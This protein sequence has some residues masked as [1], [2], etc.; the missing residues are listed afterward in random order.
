[1]FQ[2]DT[3]DQFLSVGKRSEK[4][5]RR[6]LTSLAVFVGPV[7]AG[8]QLTDGHV[9]FQ[10]VDTAIGVRML[11]PYDSQ[12]FAQSAHF[13]RT[14]DC[15]SARVHEIDHVVHDVGVVVRQ[16]NDI[17]TGV[18][19]RTSIEGRVQIGTCRRQYRTVGERHALARNQRR[20]AEEAAMTKVNEKRGEFPGVF[21][22]DVIDAERRAA[23]SDTEHC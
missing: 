3:V 10:L 15:R 19:D 23:C 13:D 6:C 7:V 22:F 4:F 14:S 18:D 17:R 16:V 1:M 9:E 21:V 5:E 2:S 11:P 20:V 8:K 12:T